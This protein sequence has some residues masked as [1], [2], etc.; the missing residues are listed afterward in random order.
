MPESVVPAGPA[1]I[2][3]H[4]LAADLVAEVRTW[5]VKLK[6]NAK[7]MASLVTES[8]SRLTDTPGIGAVTAARLLGRT[9]KPTRFPTSSAF[10]QY[11]GTAPIEIASADRARHRLSQRG[12][13]QLNAALHTVAIT[14]IRMPGTRGHAYYQAKLAE[15]KTSREAQRCLK[16]RLPDHVWRTMMTDERRRTRMTGPGGQTGTTTESSAAGSTPTA[17]SSDKSLPGP[18]GNEPTPPP[19]AA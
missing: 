1:E 15:G 19:H 6:D 14:Q 13:C 16:R 18:A 2:T 12:D 5:D 9:G 17:D 11:A 4:T 8:G 7:A 10:A 3:R